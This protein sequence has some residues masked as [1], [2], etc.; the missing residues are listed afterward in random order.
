[1][2]CEDAKRNK[3]G[4]LVGVGGDDEA[5]RNMCER[6]CL[7]V[8]VYEREIERERVREKDREED[9]EKEREKD[10]DRHFCSPHLNSTVGMR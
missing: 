8:C 3:E 4:H 9:R 5:V 7:C 10:R 1:V 6:V 2:T